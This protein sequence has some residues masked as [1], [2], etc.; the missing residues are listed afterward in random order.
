MAHHRTTSV[1]S[2]SSISS[3]EAVESYRDPL[4]QQSITRSRTSIQPLEVLLTRARHIIENFSNHEE[5][6]YKFQEKSI[7]LDKILTAMLSHARQAGGERAERYVSSA[8]VASFDADKTFG[9]LVAVAI[10]WLT[11]LLYICM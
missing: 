6:I 1:E 9:K 5:R 8:I 3:E 4:L 7:N 11:H 2:A 10:T